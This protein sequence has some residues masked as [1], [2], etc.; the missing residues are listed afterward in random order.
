M[1]QIHAPITI[2]SV[3]IILFFSSQRCWHGI[4]SQ[5]QHKGGKNYQFG[6]GSIVVAQILHLLLLLIRCFQN[7]D[8]KTVI[9][10]HIPVHQCHMLL[11]I[12]RIIQSFIQPDIFLKFFHLTIKRICRYW[13]LHLIN[14]LHIRDFYL[15]FRKVQIFVF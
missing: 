5:F 13:K 8:N 7:W 10:W 12:H 14:L 2:R 3:C 9:L 11:Q 4:I 15:C 1:S 6:T